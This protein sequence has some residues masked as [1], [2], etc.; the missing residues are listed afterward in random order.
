MKMTWFGNPA[1]GPAYKKTFWI[2]FGLV[3]FNRTIDIIYG[4]TPA[5]PDEVDGEIVMVDNPDCSDFAVSVSNF[6]TFWFGAYLFYVTFKLRGAVRAKYGI[7]GGCCADFC[8]VALCP[9]CSAVQM[10]HQTADYETGEAMCCTTDGLS[11]SDENEVLVQ[12]ITV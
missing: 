9:C 11:S 5:Y 10:A 2:V 4:C 7:P 12:A 3:L 1:E 6:V 8:T